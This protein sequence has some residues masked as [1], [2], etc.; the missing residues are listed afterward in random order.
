VIISLK[1]ITDKQ[2]L[3]LN[4]YT[5]IVNMKITVFILQRKS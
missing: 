4:T 1:K 5:T 2:P 3:I